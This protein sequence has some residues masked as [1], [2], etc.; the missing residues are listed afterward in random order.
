VSQ[1]ELV[2]GHLNWFFQYFHLLEGL[3]REEQEELLKQ[4]MPSLAQTAG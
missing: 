1:A 2:E 4:K 3:S